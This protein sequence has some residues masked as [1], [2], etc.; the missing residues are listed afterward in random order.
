MKDATILLRGEHPQDG[1]PFR[2]LAAMTVRVGPCALV[3][4]LLAGCLYEQPVAP[5][6][7]RKRWTRMSSGPGNGVNP[8][9]EKVETL[10]V[11]ERP[12]H[13]YRAQFDEGDDDPAVFVGYQ[14]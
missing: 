11:T 4:G 6:G 13:R 8:E 2:A 7:G 10:T 14:R 3:R 1:P 9:G 5:R 12:D